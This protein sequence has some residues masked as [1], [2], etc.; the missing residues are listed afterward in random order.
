MKITPDASLFQALSS[1]PRTSRENITPAPNQQTADG[2]PVK[3]R[4]DSLQ[5][6]QARETARQ[7]AIRLNRDAI[8]KMQQQLREREREQARYMAQAPAQAAQTAAPAQAASPS[9][10]SQSSAR[11]AN[12]NYREAPGADDRPRYQ[13]L[14]QFID[15]SV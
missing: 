6:M 1:F 13:R 10:L 8:D 14:G 9:A 3:A 12:P 5:E 7:E 4:A 2:R 11:P 15:I